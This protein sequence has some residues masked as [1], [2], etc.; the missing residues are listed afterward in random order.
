MKLILAVAMFF[1]LVLIGIGNYQAWSSGVLPGLAMTFATVLALA[2]FAQV[3][4]R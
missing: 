3:L 4:R 2:G 1:F